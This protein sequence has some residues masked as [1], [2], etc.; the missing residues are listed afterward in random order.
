MIATLRGM[1]YVCV[2]LYHGRG[3]SLGGLVLLSLTHSIAWIQPDS[4]VTEMGEVILEPARIE[5]WV[6]QSPR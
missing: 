2:L 6:S 3:V 5:D 4:S 1:F